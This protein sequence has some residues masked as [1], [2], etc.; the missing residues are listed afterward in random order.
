M[1]LIQSR[2]PAKGSCETVVRALALKEKA[3]QPN[4]ENVAAEPVTKGASPASEA[5]ET[6]PKR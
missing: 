3:G 1:T 2:I 6:S 4:A 5:V